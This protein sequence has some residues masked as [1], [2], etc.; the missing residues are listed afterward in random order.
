MFKLL[1]K[2]YHLLIILVSLVGCES[3]G[4][5]HGVSEGS[6]VEFAYEQVFFDR[7]GELSITMPDGERYAGKFVQKSSSTSGDSWEIGESSG[8]DSFIING[9]DTV[10]SQ[11]EAILIG[12]RGSTMTCEFQFANPSYGIEGGGIGSC[13]TSASKLIKITF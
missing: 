11:A 7:S 10:S 2:K 9:S 13:K 6:T 3:T 12:N 5:M 8:D 4:I 1:S